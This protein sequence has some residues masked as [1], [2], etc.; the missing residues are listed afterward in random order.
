[1]SSAAGA[2]TYLPNLIV[3]LAPKKGASLADLR[4]WAQGIGSALEQFRQLLES[5]TEAFVSSSAYISEA[6]IVTAHIQDLQV[7]TIKRQLTNVIGPTTF[8]ATALG[9]YL[10]QYT[11]AL[12]VLANGATINYGVWPQGVS[13]AW[14]SGTYLG[15]GSTN[16]DVDTWGVLFHNGMPTA[17]TFNIYM[18]WW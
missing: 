6:T 17:T 2:L 12:H 13:N 14:T 3:P 5:Q 4:T 1:M 9:N 10:Q 11:T 15:I 16:V 18:E 7:T 8:A